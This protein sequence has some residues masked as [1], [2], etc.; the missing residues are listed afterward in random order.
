MHGWRLMEIVSQKRVS[1]LLGGGSGGR[2]RGRGRPAKRGRKSAES[3]MQSKYYD[4][5]GGLGSGLTI[6]NYFQA[7]KKA[8]R[9]AQM[10]SISAWIEWREEAKA[11]RLSATYNLAP[12]DDLVPA[13]HAF[14][15][16]EQVQQLLHVQM[17]ASRV[18][19]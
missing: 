1:H 3:V 15:T 16:P 18:K 4:G 9:T 17:L 13:V 8:R 6:H 5:S 10:Q 12:T 2:H 14:A 19:E 11:K 7:H